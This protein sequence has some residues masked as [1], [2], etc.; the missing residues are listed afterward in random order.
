MDIEVSEIKKNKEDTDVVD[1]DSKSVFQEV[2][3]NIEPPISEGKVK[4]KVE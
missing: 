3:E 4:Q 1:K 2:L